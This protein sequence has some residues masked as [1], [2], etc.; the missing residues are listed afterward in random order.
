LQHPVS[1]IFVLH[2]WAEPCE[3]VIFSQL[4][5]R[6]KYWAKDETK[7]TEKY[8]FCLMIEKTNTQTI[9][10]L[11]PKISETKIPFVGDIA[12]GF[13]S[14]AEDFI[15]DSIDLNELLIEHKES[16]FLARVKGSSMDNDFKDRDLLV[17]DR[18]LEWEENK[19]ALC[20]VDGA[21]TLKRIKINDGKCYLM[22]SNKNFPLIE[23][24]YEQ[25]VFVW[26]IIRYS[27][28]KH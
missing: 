11:R 8:Y 10:L 20:Y 6:T 22:P 3:T 28:R 18:S 19:I 5:R 27:I 26:G 25:G 17:I 15:T 14:A 16:T 9:E 1:S 24:N 23:V 7:L 2:N 21:F 4:L 13:P 12:A